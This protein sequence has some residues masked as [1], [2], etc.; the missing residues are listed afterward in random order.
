MPASDPSANMMNNGGF[1]MDQHNQMSM[2]RTWPQSQS[3]PVLDLP[4]SMQM[5][6]GY[7]RSANQSQ[8]PMTGLRQ[9]DIPAEQRSRP[10]SMSMSRG[11]SQGSQIPGEMP[12]AVNM[13]FRNI[14]PEM[15]R[16]TPGTEGLFS[17]IARS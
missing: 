7:S 2:F 15:R 1:R 13:G 10:H 3:I 9:Q 17:N 14:P 12:G 5:A 16:G 8:M 4:P 11:A 6:M